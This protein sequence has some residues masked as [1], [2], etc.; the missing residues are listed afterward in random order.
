MFSDVAVDDFAVNP[1]VVTGTYRQ[2][3]P[4]WEMQNLQLLVN[5]VVHQIYQLK[6][7]IT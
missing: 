2:R 4:Y 3:V 6:N 5:L 1:T 7:V